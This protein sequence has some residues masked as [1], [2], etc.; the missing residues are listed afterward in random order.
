MGTNFCAYELDRGA[1]KVDAQKCDISVYLLTSESHQPIGDARVGVRSIDFAHLSLSPDR[2]LNRPR[3]RPSA[4][5]SPL[6]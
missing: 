2:F 4:M 5:M 1:D 3:A 6:L